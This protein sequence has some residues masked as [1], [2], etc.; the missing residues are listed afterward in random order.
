MEQPCLHCRT[1]VGF[2]QTGPDLLRLLAK[3]ALPS[4]P[5][6]A[7]LAG[8]GVCDLS[9]CEGSVFIIKP[10]VS[11]FKQIFLLGVLTYIGKFKCIFLIFLSLNSLHDM[12]RCTLYN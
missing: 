12:N 2:K 9:G 6:P 10:L 7:G 11:R 1:S 4:L 3:I 8:I 5:L